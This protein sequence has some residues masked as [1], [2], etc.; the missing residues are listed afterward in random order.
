M[1]PP[2]LPCRRCGVTAGKMTV[3]WKAAPNGSLAPYAAQCRPR[4]PKS[5]PARQDKPAQA[6]TRTAI[7]PGLCPA[8]GFDIVPGDVIAGAEGQSFHYECSP[9]E[10][11]RDRTWQRAGDATG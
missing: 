9:N 8:C 1:T 11:S 10:T 7:R 3:L 4:C 2:G 5:T 6:R